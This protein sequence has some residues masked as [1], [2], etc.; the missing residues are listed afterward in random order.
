MRRAGS[1]QPN[2]S[3]ARPCRPASIRCPNQARRPTNPQTLQECPGSPAEQLTSISW[4]APVRA[5]V[6]GG[7]VAVREWSGF[8]RLEA[9]TRRAWVAAAVERLR[10]FPFWPLHRARPAAGRN[11]PAPP[12]SDNFPALRVHSLRSPGNFPPDEGGCAPRPQVGHQLRRP[13]G[14][15]NGRDRISLHTGHAARRQSTRGHP[16]NI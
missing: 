15:K 3:A 14:Q 11:P 7:R 8:V 13:A 12:P 16:P 9:S 2:W 4:W 6:P 10:L 5:R 1:P